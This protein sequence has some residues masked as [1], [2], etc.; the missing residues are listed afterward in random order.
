MSAFSINLFIDKRVKALLDLFASSQHTTTENILGSAIRSQ[1][2]LFKDD[3]KA[4]IINLANADIKDLEQEL[5]RLRQDRDTK[6]KLAEAKKSERDQEK[7][8][9]EKWNQ[10]NTAWE[11]LNNEAQKADHALGNHYTIIED[12][13]RERDAD[14]NM[15]LKITQ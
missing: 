3:L 11:G 5:D 8:N 12:R 9:K 13:A 10:L 1:I 14:I 2:L 6:R 15:I 7:K 4:K